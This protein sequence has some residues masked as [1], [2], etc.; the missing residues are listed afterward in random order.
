MTSTISSRKEPENTE[1]ASFP[2]LSTMEM[3]NKMSH[4]AV[5]QDTATLPLCQ[6]ALAWLTLPL[7]RRELSKSIVKPF[8]PELSRGLKYG[9]RKY[10]FLTSLLAPVGL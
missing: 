6:L 7:R 10:T 1:L 8:L 4:N 5:L 9:M 3:D 2:H